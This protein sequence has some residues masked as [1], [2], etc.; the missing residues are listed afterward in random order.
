MNKYFMNIK[1]NFFP[2]IKRKLNNLF[3]NRTIAAPLRSHSQHFTQK[4]KKTS[5]QL[6]SFFLIGIVAITLLTTPANNSSAEEKLGNAVI[7]TNPIETEHVVSLIKEGKKEPV[8]IHT[9]DDELING[10]VAE[11]ENFTQQQEKDEETITE[12]KNKK[13]KSLGVY[14]APPASP[15]A[16]FTYYDIPLSYEWQVYTYNICQEY[17][18]SYEIML[19]LMFS[20]SNFRFNC[21]SGVAWGI[22][23][24]HQCHESYAKSIGIENYKEP[25]GNIRLGAIF[26]SK[27]LKNQGGDYHRALIC[28]NYGAGG[29]QKHC[30]SQGI[31]Q[32]GYS[33][34]VMAYAHNLTPVT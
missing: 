1:G 31:Y 13:M 28:Y 2:T 21:T 33:R 29:A 9:L 32:T 19:G 18:I 7:L 11:K 34:K 5:L 6:A 3:K 26:L 4:F 15:K 25:E 12:Y 16:G 24:I 23:Q 30:F 22:C 17:G 14:K 20:E 8:A 10:L 27:H